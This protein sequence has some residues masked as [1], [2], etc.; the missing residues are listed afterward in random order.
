VAWIVS[1]LLALTKKIN[2]SLLPIQGDS[3]YLKKRIKAWD[4]YHGRITKQ[5][6][7]IQLFFRASERFSVNDSRKRS[8]EAMESFY[9]RSHECLDVKVT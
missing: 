4:E 7:L 3:I 6:H 5:G 8:S 2:A 9:K 1:R